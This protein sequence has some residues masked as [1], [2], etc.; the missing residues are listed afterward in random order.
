MQTLISAHC[1]LWTMEVVPLARG[2]EPQA[3]ALWSGLRFL[4]SETKGLHQMAS[5]ALR[6]ST[7]LELQTTSQL[8]QV[9]G[10][11][12]V[13]KGRKGIPDFFTAPLS[14]LF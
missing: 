10:D 5:K 4:P 14:K 2:L 7:Q 8:P 13:L 3:L 9:M 11:T 1:P 6:S 12:P